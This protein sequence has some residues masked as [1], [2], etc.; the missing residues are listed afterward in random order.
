VETTVPTKI[1]C[2]FDEAIEPRGIGDALTEYSRTRQWSVIAPH[3]KPG[4]RPNTWIVR[5]IPGSLFDSY[6]MAA[7]SESERI[8]RA[9]RASVVSGENVRKSN[10]EIV[11]SVNFR[12]GLRADEMPAEALCYEIENAVRWEVGSYGVQISFLARTTG[13]TFHL[14]ES[15]L[16]ALKQIGFFAAAVSQS[17]PTGPSTD[18][19]STSKEADTAQALEETG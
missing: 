1:I 5:P 3:I 8:G 19:P 18:E 7:S 12:D 11:P 9:F 6:V 10:G 13:R 4:S 17:E 14:P 2:T 15:S 16:T